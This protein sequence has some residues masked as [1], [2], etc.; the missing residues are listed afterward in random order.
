[1][2]LVPF[3]REGAMPRYLLSAIR[4]RAFQLARSGDFTDCRSI[5]AEL[6]KSERGRAGLALSDPTIRS[7]ID[8]L[9]ADAGQRF[10]SATGL[11]DAGDM[12][13]D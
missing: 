10:E 1:M 2:G 7:H 13:P 6:D 5:E 3:Q 8:L 12:R 9:C 11:T 4:I